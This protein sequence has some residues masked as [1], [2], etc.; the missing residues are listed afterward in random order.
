LAQQIW[1]DPELAHAQ[2]AKAGTL[3]ERFNRD[4]WNEEAHTFL[5]ALAGPDKNRVD[6]TTSNAGQLLWSGIVDPEHAGPLVERLMC[7][8]LFSGWGLRTMSSGE[9]AFSELRYHNGCVW[10]HDTALVAWG[11]RRYGFEEQAL[12]LADA[13]LAVAAAFRHQ[14]PEVF[15]GFERDR[16]EAPIRY[17][18]ALTPQAWA[19]GAPLLVLRTVLGLD[20]DGEEL[21]SDPRFLGG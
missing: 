8:D 14:L 20:P 13:L 9:A 12:A 16:S 17:P 5:L 3:R 18:S 10:P 21:H 4:F 19:A 15:A 2:E 6:A 11:M 7:P 1:R